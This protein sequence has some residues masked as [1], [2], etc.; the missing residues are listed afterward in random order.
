MKKNKYT[1]G[2]LGSGSWGGTLTYLISKNNYNVKLW[3]FSKEEYN[4]L[5]KTRKLIRPIQV[6]LQKNVEVTTNLQDVVSSCNILIIA[7]PSSALES[8][9]KSI[10]KLNIKKST[11][12][13]IASKGINEKT[14]LTP[15]Q[16]LKKH[17]TKNEIAILSGPNIALDVISSKP[18]VS[19]IA[20]KNLKA[21]KILQKIISSKNFRLYIN[22]DITGVEIAAAFKN[23]I[24]IASGICDG[25]GFPISSKSALIS[26]GLIEIARIGIREGAKLNTMFSAA[27]LGDL[28]AT[29][30]SPNS[31]NYRVGFNLAK[32]KKL[33]RILKELGEVA[34]GVLNVRTMHKL[35]KKHKIQA[36]IAESV[37]NVI[38]MNKNPKTELQKLLNRNIPEKELV[39]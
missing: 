22:E 11:L 20:T 33:K 15:S 39:F 32:G 13:L 14:E 38:V 25:F 18:M 2:V 17:L 24:A 16:I 31:R 4:Q 29:C 21:G 9:A 28:I 19:V 8:L 12:I 1:V 26:R 6:K 10:Q 23:V 30:C 5:S 27:G 35:A 7:V 3:T 36:P 34:E 37:Y